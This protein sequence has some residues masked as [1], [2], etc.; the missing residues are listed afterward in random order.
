M[1]ALMII[2]NQS[3]SEIVDHVLNE[4]SIRG[5][6]KWS[7]VQGRGTVNGLPHLGTHAWPSKNMVI[8]SI[9]TPEQMNSLVPRLQEISNAADKQGLRVFAWEAESVVS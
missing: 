4:H 7:D 3:L 5:Y 6:T 9:V 8:L 1:K 2:Y